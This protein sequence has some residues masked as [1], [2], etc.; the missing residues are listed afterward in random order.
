MFTSFSPSGIK[1][2]LEVYVGLYVE[3][4]QVSG[5]PNSNVVTPY[6]AKL[7]IICPPHH[8]TLFYLP[9]VIKLHI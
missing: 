1:I 9:E 7:C 8:F 6:L 4:S 3:I 2:N 5:I